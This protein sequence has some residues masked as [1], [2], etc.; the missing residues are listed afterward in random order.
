MSTEVEL[1]FKIEKSQ[2]EQIAGDL[3]L[4]SIMHRKRI[5]EIKDT[6]LNN[7]LKDM[8]ASD[9]ALRIRQEKSFE[10]HHPIDTMITYKGP[11]IDAETKSREEIEIKID[12]TL[13]ET[14]TFF[15]KLG[16]QVT[17]TTTKLREY[18]FIPCRYNKEANA[19][20]FNNFDFRDGK[21]LSPDGL[22]LI[23]VV[24]E[25]ED[26]GWF[27]EIEGTADRSELYEETKQMVLEFAKFLKL[28]N[29]IRESYMELLRKNGNR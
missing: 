11:K 28:E 8:I 29:P 26:L 2:I 4:D 1:K 22:E 23:L 27:V 9:E 13:E 10:R 6:Y 19:Y 17:G 5:R 21:G 16:F 20:Q 14:T 15:E 3:R 7:T 24:D 12:G 25:V 18:Y